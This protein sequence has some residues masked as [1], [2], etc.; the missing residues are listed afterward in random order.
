VRRTRKPC[1]LL[2][3]LTRACAAGTVSDSAPRKGRLRSS[4]QLPTPPQ[5]KH[6]RPLIH[7]SDAALAAH[8]AAERLRVHLLNVLQHKGDGD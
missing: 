6:V 8:C 2:S 1:K 3:I 7:W 5:Q 4:L